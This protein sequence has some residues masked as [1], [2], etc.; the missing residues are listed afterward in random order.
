MKRF[1]PA[2]LLAMLIA[3]PVFA[4]TEDSPE[5]DSQIEYKWELNQKG[6]QYLKLALGPSFPLN[7]GNIFKSGSSQLVLG[8][9]GSLGYHY[10]F[11]KDMAVGIDATF[12]FNTSIGGHVFNFIPIV[13]KF[14]WQ[15][16]VGKFEF[17]LTAGIGFAWHTYIGYTYWPALVFNAEAGVLYRLSA[18]WAVG[19]EAIYLCMPE[20]DYKDM[21]KSVWGQFL[22]VNVTARYYF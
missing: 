18:N 11:A 21:S 6:D 16:S 4:Q 13:A 1:L 17:P 20:F 14:T 15:P 12:G 7:F 8:G 9:A 3:T 19:G 22:N 10:F 5:T 2:A